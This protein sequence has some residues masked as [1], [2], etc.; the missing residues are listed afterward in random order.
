MSD[1]FEVVPEDGQPWWA[2]VKTPT[3]EVPVRVKS[4]TV[5]PEGVTAELTELR[6]VD[7]SP[8]NIGALKRMSRDEA[9][10]QV[11]TW[12]KTGGTA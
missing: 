6:G 11:A 10:A 8:E 12:S 1:G 4:W 5:T 3:G 2:M 9:W 7:T